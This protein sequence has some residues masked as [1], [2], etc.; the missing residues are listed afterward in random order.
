MTADVKH[1]R[2]ATSGKGTQAGEAESEAV[3]PDL[4]STDAELAAIVAIWSALS[5]AIKAGIRALVEAAVKP[6]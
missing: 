6:T 4:P 3:R 5:A 1:H 2:D